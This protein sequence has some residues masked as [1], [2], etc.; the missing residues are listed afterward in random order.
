MSKKTRI[1]KAEQFRRDGKYG[2]SPVPICYEITD[3]AIVRYLERVKGVDIQAVC[4]EILADGRRDVI[5]KL[6]NCRIKVANRMR[7]IVRLGTVVTVL[8]EE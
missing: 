1:Q 3:H 4:A 6:R 2:E 5:K 8:P 7:L